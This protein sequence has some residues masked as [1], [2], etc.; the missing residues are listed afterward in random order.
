MDTPSY[1]E[2]GDGY[3]LTAPLMHWFMDHYVDPKDRFDPRVA[4]LRADDLS[5]LPPAFIVTAEFDP[6]R[7]EGIAYARALAAAGTPVTHYAA[8]GHTHTSV[9]AVD[10]MLSG[11]A[12]R[13]RMADAL[14]RFLGASVPA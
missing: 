5:G 11:A 12:V 1:V 6:L 9:P 4:P 10:M 13:E 3:I 14:V 7:D 8:H 2:N